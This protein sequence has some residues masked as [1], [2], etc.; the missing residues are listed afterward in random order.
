M[1]V[2]PFSRETERIS[3]QTELIKFFKF[4]SK[5]LKPK[6]TRYTSNWALFKPNMTLQAPPKQANTVL[7]KLDTFKIKLN[8]FQNQTSVFGIKLQALQKS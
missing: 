5:R 2:V 7:S 6:R 3:S 4:N 1:K 8:I